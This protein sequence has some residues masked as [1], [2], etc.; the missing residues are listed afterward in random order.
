MLKKTSHKIFSIVMAFLVLCSTVSFTIQ[1]HFCGDTLIDVAMFSK[2]IDCGMDMDALNI[3][4]FTKKNCCKDEIVIIK[5]QDKLKITSFEDLHFIH[6]LFLST[7]SYSYTSLF[8]GLLEQS[9]PHKDYSP[10]NLVADI[11]ILDQVFLI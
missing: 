1:K 11:H 2:P 6:Q 7:F 8:E 10:P 3:N 5:G 9:S 4:S